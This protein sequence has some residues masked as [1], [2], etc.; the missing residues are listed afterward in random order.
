M[1]ATQETLAKAM[2]ARRIPSRA[3]YT[4]LD[5]VIELAP[6]AQLQTSLEETSSLREEYT[7]EKLG[8]VIMGH[9]ARGEV[10]MHPGN[11][12]RDDYRDRWLD[13]R[14]ARLDDRLNHHTQVV[15]QRLSAYEA[16]LDQFLL[17]MR[18]RDNQRHAEN[19]SIQQTLS[20]LQ[21]SNKQVIMAL[22]I[23]FVSIA[24]AIIAGLLLQPILTP[25]QAPLQ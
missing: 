23:G 13:E 2:V 11:G 4:G 1:M 16:K 19:V 21:T 10:P 6:S 9:W 17:E 22:I 24:V 5:N 18:D 3:R 14:F 20:S 7:W 12:T 8:H 15:E 25:P